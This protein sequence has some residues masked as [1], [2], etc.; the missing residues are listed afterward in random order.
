MLEFVLAPQNFPFT[1][2]LTAMLIIAA[3]EGVGAMMGAGLS[4]ILD[5]LIPNADIDLGVDGPDLDAP[6][7]IGKVLS[8][9]CVKRVPVLVLLV[10]FLLLFGIVGLLI[11]DCMQTLFGFLLP[12]LVAAVL[13]LVATLPMVRGTATI[14]AKIIPQDETSAISRDSLIGRCAEITLGAARQGYPTQA[15]TKDRFG[16]V[17]YL[18]LEPDEPEEIFNKGDVVLLVKHDGVR[19]FAIRP[20]NQELMNS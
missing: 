9:F 13:A 17:H 6:G 4:S 2:A 16:K 19:F 18:M 1:T 10:V 3:I 14:L 11:Q 12:A 7:P 8:W 15:K 5:Q 20:D